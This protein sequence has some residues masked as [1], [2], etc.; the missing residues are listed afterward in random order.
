MLRDLSFTLPAGSKVAVVG[1][2][3][4]GKSSL[5]SVL[6]RLY[7]PDSSSKITLDG[8]EICTLSLSEARKAFSLIPQTPFLFAGSVRD[9]LD[10]FG[11]HPDHL[12]WQIL[13]RVQLDSQVRELPL[14]LNQSLTEGR[15]SLG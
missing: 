9:N 11:Q 3:G 10:P 8:C 12:I 7:E 4:A 15:L 5:L 1:R 14:G 6:F 2:T 13:A